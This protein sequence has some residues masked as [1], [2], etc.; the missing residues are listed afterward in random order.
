M[1]TNA[2]DRQQLVIASDSR[3]SYIQN[4]YVIYVDDVDFD[5]IAWRASGAMICAGNGMLIEAWKDWFL[6]PMP[7]NHAP[8]TETVTP[9]G[10]PDSI[11]VT[12]FQAGTGD[13]LF[14]YGWYLPFDDVAYFAGT[15]AEYAHRCFAENRCA[16]TSVRSAGL[17]DPRTGGETKLLNLVDGTNNLGTGLKRLNQIDF[18]FEKKGMAMNIE[19]KNVIS[20]AEY[21][22]GQDQANV[23]KPNAANLSAPTG[24]AMKPWTEDNKRRLVSVVRAMAETE[25]ANGDKQGE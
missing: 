16:E 12:V 9:L 11:M 18:D 10:E 17:S 22:A 15:G 21:A 13:V 19:T 4:G 20:F 24:Q 23:A 1:T 14:S 25:N 7:S 2:I 8:A 6:S 3:W 5:K